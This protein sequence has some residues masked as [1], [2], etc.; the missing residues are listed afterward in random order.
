MLTS[1]SMPPV[2][3]RALAF[4]MFLLVTSC[5]VQQMAATVSSDSRVVF[6]P[7]RRL[8]RSLIAYFPESEEGERNVTLQHSCEQ[9]LMQ[10]HAEINFKH[11]FFFLHVTYCISGCM[12]Q[13]PTLHFVPFISWM[14]HGFSLRLQWGKAVF[15]NDFALQLQGRQ[16][17]CVCASLC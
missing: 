14:V 17:V 8:T 1:F 15:R 16:T 12:P 13:W 9:K 10:R 3:A 7:G 4:S 11:F 6:P 2:S 5:R